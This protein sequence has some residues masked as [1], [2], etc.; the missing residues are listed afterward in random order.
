MSKYQH[1]ESPIYIDGTDI[2]KNKLNITNSQLLHEIENNLLKEAYTLFAS[3]INNQT[4]FNE[5]YFINLH[6]KTFE[7]LYDFAGIYRNVN[8]S[9]GDSQFCIALYLQNESTRI[10]NELEQDNYLSNIINKNEFVKKIAYYQAELIALHPFYEL[11]G[12]ILRLF[13]DMI[14]INNGYNPIDYTNS[15]DNGAY[16]KASIECVQYANTL[17]LEDII[18]NGLINIHL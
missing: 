9:K 12:R 18:I 17:K 10:F 4:K 6:K 3:K 1:D 13:F 5:I 16:I 11:N 8:M 15:I 14:C 2:P 7:S